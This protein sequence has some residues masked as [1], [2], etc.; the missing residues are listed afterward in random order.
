M[1]ACSWAFAWWLAFFPRP[2]LILWVSWVPGTLSG[3]WF[4]SRLLSPSWVPPP[5]LST[6]TCLAAAKSSVPHEPRSPEP[7]QQN[8]QARLRS[9]SIA[10][11]YPVSTGG[12]LLHKGGMFSPPASGTKKTFHVGMFPVFE[13]GILPHDTTHSRPVI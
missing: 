5:I 12:F 6:A 3:Y 2:L 9:G 8:L 7:V 13:S 4:S 11:R 1:P 10:Y